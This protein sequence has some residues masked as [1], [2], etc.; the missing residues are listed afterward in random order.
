EQQ[1]AQSVIVVQD[2]FTTH[3][4]ARLVMDVVELLTRLDLRVFV[5]PFSANGKPLQVQGFLGAFARTA[6]QQARRLRA[7]QEFDVPLVGIDPAMTLTY[8]QEYVKTLGAGQVP[9]VLLLQEWLATRLD[10]L[11]IGTLE[12]TDPGFKLLSHCTEKTNAPASPRAW[13]QVFAA[14]GLTL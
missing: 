3:F 1:R 7:L 11:A 12:L 14:F 2:A 6:E 10:T 9:A 4:E 8:R 13:Q 5:M